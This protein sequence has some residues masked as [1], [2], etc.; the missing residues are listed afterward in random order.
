AVQ[1]RATRVINALQE[2]AVATQADLLSFLSS[3]SPDELSQFTPY[4][5]ANIVL[6]EGTPSL[7]KQISHR[8]DVSFMDF[9]YVPEPDDAVDEGPAA[10]SVPNGSEPGLRA[11]NA[12]K[13]WALGYTGA[14]RLV[15][16]IDTGVDVTH[17]ALS[18]SWRGNSVPLSQAWL[19]DSTM[20][21]GCEDHGTHVMG[22]ILGLNPSTNDTTGVAPGA[23]WIA[24][25][26]INCGVSTI[27]AFQWAMDPD[28]NPGTI[29]DMPDVIANS[30]GIGSGGGCLTQTYGSVLNAVETAGIAVVFSA[31]N[32]GPSAGTITGPK[33][34]NFTLV[35][36][37]AT[38]N[39]DANTPGFPMRNSSSRGPSGCGGSGPLLIKPEA[40]APGVSV[41][42]TVFNGN[43]GLKSGTSMACPHVAGSVTLLKQMYPNKTGAELK[44]ALYETARETPS[45]LEANDPGEPVGST[46]GEDNNFGRGLIDVFAAAAHLSPYQILGSII[47]SRDTLPVPNALVDIL[48]TGLQTISDTIGLFAIGSLADSVEV[49]VSA[50]AHFD[51]SIVLQLTP[52][53]PETVNVVLRALPLAVMSG[54]VTDSV[55]GAGVVADIELYEASDVSPG[56]TVTTR[57]GPDGSYSVPTLAGTYRIVVFPSAPYEDSVMRDSV[58]LTAGGTSADFTLREATVLL[59]D[60]DA[61]KMY[62]QYYQQSLDRLGFVR[63]TFSIAD[64]GTTPASVMSVFTR[65]PAIVWFTAED[66]TD[67][68]T[69]QERQLIIEHLANGG[70]LLLTGQNIAQT[71][72]P[73]DTL[74]NGWFGFQGNGDNSNLFVKGFDGDIIGD[75][76]NYPFTAGP[77]NQTS[78]D[79]LTITGTG[80]GTPT[81][82]MFYRFPANDTTAI[83][84]V[85]VR[86]TGPVWAVTFFGFGLD[87]LTADRMDTLIVR[88]FR[89]FDQSVTGVREVSG[90]EHPVTFWLEQNYPNPFNPATT[91]RY[92]LPEQSQ[93]LLVIYDMTG[94]RVRRLFDQE[95]EPGIH[96]VEWN[97][98]ND[99][100]L[101]VATGMYVLSLEV[102]GR[103]GT[104]FSQIRKMLL[105]K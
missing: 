73:D 25:Q 54:S 19:G 42:S 82:T 60:D 101:E 79:Q 57:S 83:A 71:S 26:A 6:V 8:R 98:L 44:M 22:T 77:S 11:I 37:W 62:E 16:N 90:S 68:L 67:A 97:G 94:R 41:R 70:N 29:T 48:G 39:V 93:V 47:S 45:D 52:D 36:T 28:G 3:R 84:A 76:V 64:S 105:M 38:G 75:G 10:V 88:S 1:Q 87:G 17:P 55:T 12:H 2:K 56:P 80:I 81:K 59:V 72:A 20:P 40:V 96:A 104:S 49:H 51:T 7:L 5:V 63:R 78:K 99:R 66:T 18:S 100:G 24:A 95:M 85:R 27:S 103:G 14:G 43:Y 34:I 30:W 89:Y 69:L 31:G 4:W 53:I 33:N 13:L 35:N 21:Y 32:S 92:N 86:G 23:E 46:T 15:M 74:L 58:I 65:T 91:I 50:Y 9:D 61:G 102:T